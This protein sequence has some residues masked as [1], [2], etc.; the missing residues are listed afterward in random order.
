MA[1]TQAAHAAVTH[2]ELPTHVPQATIS[3]AWA[4]AMSVTQS[5]STITQ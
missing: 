2:P 4:F 5:V 1:A 3:T